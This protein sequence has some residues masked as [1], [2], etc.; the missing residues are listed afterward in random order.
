MDLLTPVSYTRYID[1]H[2]TSHS[3]YTKR[4]VIP[5]YK[6]GIIN[7]RDALRRRNALQNRGYTVNPAWP[8]QFQSLTSASHQRISWRWHNG[9]NS[10]C[11]VRISL[12]YADYDS[13]NKL[14]VYV[15]IAMSIWHVALG[16][17]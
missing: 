11:P 13:Y 14:S 5:H 15:P 17:P 3:R 9:P 2:G 12:C 4:E 16:S 8:S 1:D 7:H 10:A 6:H